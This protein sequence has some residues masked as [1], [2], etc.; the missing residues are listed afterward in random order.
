MYV[1]RKCSKPRLC[2]RDVCHCVGACAYQRPISCAPNT[3]RW[4]K[5]GSRKEE[6]NRWVN[7]ENITADINNIN[8]N[9]DNYRWVPRAQAARRPQG[10]ARDAQISASLKDMQEKYSLT[11]THVPAKKVYGAA[12][13]PT[14]KFEINGVETISVMRKSDLILVKD[15][16][17]WVP[18][19]KYFR[20]YAP[21]E[22]NPDSNG[23]PDLV[24][25]YAPPA[26]SVVVLLYACALVYCQW[27]SHIANSQD[28]HGSDSSVTL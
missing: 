23:P 27:A 22:R 8:T 2:E 16:N 12:K 24:E 7:C 28:P 10:L 14:E 5:N 17:A 3:F 13:A 19:R 26:T 25:A 4:V 20:K 6:T 18:L 11:I 21:I 1:S 9:N 15:G